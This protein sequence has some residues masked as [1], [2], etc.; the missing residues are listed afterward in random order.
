MGIQYSGGMIVGAP[1]DNIPY[2]EEEFE[3]SWLYYEVL[4]DQ[5]IVSY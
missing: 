1:A 2:D 5:G 4:E 3:D